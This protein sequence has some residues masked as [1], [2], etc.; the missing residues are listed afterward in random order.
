MLYLENGKYL[1]R[2]TILPFIMC[3]I[4]LT[5]IDIGVRY[6]INSYF[7]KRFVTFVVFYDYEFQLIRLLLKEITV[8]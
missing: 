2:L 7:I 4:S 5:C 8:G 3:P 1:F 6:D